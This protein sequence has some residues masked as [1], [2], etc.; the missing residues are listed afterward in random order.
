MNND[1]VCI[2]YSRS[3]KTRQTMAEI[4]AALDCEVYALTDGVRRCGV[5]G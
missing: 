5:M 2:C 1:I 3:G 4:A